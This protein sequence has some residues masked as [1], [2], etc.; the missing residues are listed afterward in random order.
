MSA[1]RR[2]RLADL[3]RDRFGNSQS[4]FAARVDRQA[5]YISRQING[6]K[7]FG[8]KLARE[9][10]R[11]IGLEP[12]YFDQPIRDPAT[13]VRESAAV[14]TAIAPDDYPALVAHRVRDWDEG[15]Q[16]ALLNFIESIN[17]ARNERYA[18]RRKP[19]APHRQK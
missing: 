8:E 17:A 14:Y 7:G 3:I 10:E 2:K 9:Y 12:G 5:D 15:E 11:I 4:T 18:R 1:T 6:S 16:L 13:G 19:R